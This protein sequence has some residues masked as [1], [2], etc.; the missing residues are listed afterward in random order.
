MTTVDQ[1]TLIYNIT[2]FCSQDMS[3]PSQTAFQADDETRAS[4]SVGGGNSS[5]FTPPL[6]KDCTETVHRMHSLLMHLLSNP[7]EFESAI[8]YYKTKSTTNTLSDFQGEFDKSTDVGG[9]FG[10]E[11]EEIPIVFMVFAHDAEVVLPQAHTASQLFG[12]ER[13]GGIEL[14]AASGIVSLCQLFLRWLAL[15]PGGDHTHIIEPPGLTVMKIAGGRYRVTAA[16]RVVWTWNNEFLADPAASPNQAEL[17]FGDLV[18]MIVVDVFETDCDGRL[19]SY[20]PTF[21]NRAIS[22]TGVSV[23]RLRK[24]SSKI[25][26]QIKHVANSQAAVRVNRAASMLGRMSFRAVVTVKDSVQKKIDEKRKETGNQSSS[27]TDGKSVKYF[28]NK[29]DEANGGSELKSD[30]HISEA[31]ENSIKKRQQLV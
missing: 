27:P 19:L 13:E 2:S 6:F 20:C 10:I 14:E 31:E 9:S 26:S 4:L 8:T 29:L 28:E 11:E 18:Q 24:G 7:D 21:D 1:A 3:T 12:Y 22:K 15:L 5:T 30:N 17:H 16:H 23:E 25:K